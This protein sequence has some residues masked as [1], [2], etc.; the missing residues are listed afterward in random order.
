MDEDRPYRYNGIPCNKKE[1]REYVK[2][3]VFWQTM[4]YG[5]EGFKQKIIDILADPDWDSKGNPSIE[6]CLKIYLEEG[7]ID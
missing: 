6:L 4:R 3:N 1:Y 7:I 2:D 5:K